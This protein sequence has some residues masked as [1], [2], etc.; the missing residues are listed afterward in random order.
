[1]SDQPESAPPPPR[2]LLGRLRA[3]LR[4]LTAPGSDEAE[5]QAIEDAQESFYEH[6]NKMDNDSTIF[7]GP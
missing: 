6:G 4:G 5:F 2:G 7:G 3:R 1:M